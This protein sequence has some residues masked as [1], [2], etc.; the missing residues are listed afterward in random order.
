MKPVLAPD[1][2][3][4]PAAAAPMR[5]RCFPRWEARLGRQL[6]CGSSWPS[7]SA[8]HRALGHSL[9]ATAL[10]QCGCSRGSWAQLPAGSR[11]CRLGPAG[12]EHPVLREPR[13]RIAASSHTSSTGR[14]CGARK[15]AGAGDG[16]LRRVTGHRSLGAWDRGQPGKLAR[17]PLWR[18]HISLLV[19]G[20]EWELVP[21]HGGCLVLP[22]AWTQTRTVLAPQSG[23]S[24]R[25]RGLAAPSSADLDAR[26]LQTAGQG[27]C[28]SARDT[29]G[30]DGA[31]GM[32]LLPRRVQAGCCAVLSPTRTGR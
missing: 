22:A 21:L 25:R 5:S 30:R 15:G 9:G 12:E 18:P 19:S 23:N 27:Q 2:P 14:G 11:P 20:W 10:P 7:G 3:T 28:P 29:V 31:A 6:C 1:S 13:A 8:S 17:V 32:R 4:C 26:Q 24:R 16:V